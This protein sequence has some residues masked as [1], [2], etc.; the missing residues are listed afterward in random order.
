MLDKPSMI[1]RIKKFIWLH[2][3]S[4][5]PCGVARKVGLCRL[6]PYENDE[7]YFERGNGCS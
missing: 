7:L 5:V 1:E 6:C 4:H 3:T 2:V